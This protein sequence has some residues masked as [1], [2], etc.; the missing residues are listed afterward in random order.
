MSAAETGGGGTS[1][2]EETVYDCEF[3]DT[4]SFPS[5]AE[6]VA[7][8]SACTNNVNA[9][10]T[11]AAATDGGREADAEVEGLGTEEDMAAVIDKVIEEQKGVTL[12]AGVELQ[13][14]LTRRRVLSVT[15][16]A[17]RSPPRS[18]AKS[19]HAGSAGRNRAGGAGGAGGVG[20]PGGADG[21]VGGVGEGGEGDGADE[22]DVDRGAGS[23]LQQILTRRRA[24]SR[25]AQKAAAGG[26]SGGGGGGEAGG[27]GGGGGDVGAGSELQQILTRRR[28][29][30]RSAQATGGDGGNNSDEGDGSGGGGGGSGGG[31]VGEDETG[32]T[33]RRVGSVLFTDTDAITDATPASQEDEQRIAG[34]PNT[35]SASTPISTPIHLQASAGNFS[36]PP[37]GGLGGANKGDGGDRGDGGGEMAEWQRKVT[38]MSSISERFEGNLTYQWYSRT[39]VLVLW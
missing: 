28:A 37:G 19:T 32:V 27:G 25:S 18:G 21:G 9:T 38:G 13:K 29:K 7:H 17:P 14:M 5:L 34:T 11:L 23:E 30:S 22:V 15:G 39:Q 24:K 4:A 31:G 33:T 2:A 6:C 20:G 1:G 10:A 3:C 12:G 26:S 16:A 36:T 35:T 8:E